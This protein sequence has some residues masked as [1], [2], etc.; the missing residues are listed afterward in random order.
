MPGD[1]TIAQRAARDRACRCSWRS[2]RPT[3]SARRRRRMEF[4]QLG[5]DP[6]V[7]ISAEHGTGVG[8]LLDEIVEAAAGER[9]AQARRARRAAEATRAAQPDQ[10]RRDRRRHRRPAERRA[11]RRSSIG[12]CA[13]SACWSARCRARRATRSTPLLTWHR[14]QFRIVDTAGMRRPGAWRAAG[15]VEIG[16]RAAGAKQAI[17]D[18]DVVVLVIDAQRR[19]RPIRTRRSAGRPTAPAA[20]SSSSRT[21]G[22]W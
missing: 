20:A 6:V 11:S 16:Q 4:Y 7:E 19:A 21:S 18:A 17:A 15:Q 9:R 1:E 12:C 5:F 13:R 10:R 8:D 3:T 2:T 22:I 14:R